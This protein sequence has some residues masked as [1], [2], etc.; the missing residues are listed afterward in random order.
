MKTITV[1]FNDGEYD[2]EYRD[3]KL[4]H[5]FT[6]GFLEITGPDWAELIPVSRIKKI[7]VS[8]FEE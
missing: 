4:G 1:S 5:A 2:Y 3:E 8:I 6:D 7:G